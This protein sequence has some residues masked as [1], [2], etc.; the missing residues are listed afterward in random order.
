MSNVSLKARPR[1]TLRRL[2]HGGFSLPRPAEGDAFL[3]DDLAAVLGVS[4]RTVERWC[5]EG[6]IKTSLRGGYR[7]IAYEDALAFVAGGA[8]TGQ[9]RMG[10]GPA[11]EAAP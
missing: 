10:H 7:V 5:F 1:L 6:R 9:R 8:V 11:P 4:T 3:A 2:A